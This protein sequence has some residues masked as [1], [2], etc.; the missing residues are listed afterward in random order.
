M[1]TGVY[2]RT[3]PVSQETRNKMS[4]AKLGHIVNKETRNKLSKAHKGKS[5]HSKSGFTKGHKHWDNDNS[6]KNQFQNGHL[7]SE[8]KRLSGELHYNWKGGITTT[9]EKIRKSKRYIDW[10]KNIMVRDNFTCQMCRQYGGKLE[11]DHIKPFS[12]YP[13]LR[14]NN[15]NARV[16]CRDCH[17]STD[18]YAGKMR[19]YA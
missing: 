7:A 9:N 10:R 8:H 17:K 19:N 6:K 4:L 13:E 3:K 15:K 12:L 5:Y 2:I 18:T 11:V 14:F 16:L 1:P